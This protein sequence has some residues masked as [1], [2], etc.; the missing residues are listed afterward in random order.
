MRNQTSAVAKML[1]HC[2]RRATGFA[3]A[4]LDFPGDSGPAEV[5]VTARPRDARIIESRFRGCSKPWIQTAVAFRPVD[6][7]LV[8]VPVFKRRRRH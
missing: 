3:F 6:G 7:N 5:R 4:E 1:A 2:S 8:S